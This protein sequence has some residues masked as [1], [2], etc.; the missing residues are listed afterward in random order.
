MLGHPA[1]LEYVLDIERK[2]SEMTTDRAGE[3]IILIG[4][5]G[6]GKST[7]GVLLA[8]KMGM[9][10]IDTDILIQSASGQLLYQMIEKDGIEAFIKYE[11]DVLKKLVCDNCVIATG[12]S[13]VYG[14]A[15]MEHMAQLGCRVYLDLPSKIIEGRLGN[16]ST[17]GVVIREGETIEQLYEERAPLYERYADVTVDGAGTPKEVVEHVSGAVGKYK[18]D[19]AAL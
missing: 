12:G 1:A 7:I 4:M 13:A 10:F 9:G 19:R 2:G 14:K 15:A 5:P 11:E 3:N 18:K 17:R 16:I 6:S 8:K